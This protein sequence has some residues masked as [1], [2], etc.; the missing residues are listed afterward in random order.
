MRTESVVIDGTLMADGSL[1][2]DHR[3]MLSPGRVRVTLRYLDDSPL[4]DRPDVPWTD[5]S[6]SAPFDLPPPVASQSVQPRRV[7]ERSPSSLIVE[8]APAE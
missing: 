7:V 2:L 6:I 1:E 3:L 5:D 8:E 4:N